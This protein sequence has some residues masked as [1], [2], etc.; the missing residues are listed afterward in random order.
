[1]SDADAN[2]K[3]FMDKAS[4][5][6]NKRNFYIDQSKEI[7]S[8]LNNFQLSPV[9]VSILSQ[10]NIDNPKEAKAFFDSLKRLKLSY[11]NCKIM[12]EKHRYSAG[13][14]LLD[15]LGQH[16]VIIFIHTCIRSS[17]IIGASV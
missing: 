1:M 5:L 17:D 3:S 8:F 2:M 6:E 16:Q 14:E 7:S 13:F 10:S 9:E 4:E 15:G 11:N 12:V